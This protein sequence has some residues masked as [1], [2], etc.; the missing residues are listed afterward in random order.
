M[1]PDHSAAC[2]GMCLATRGASSAPMALFEYIFTTDGRRD[3]PVGA[4][5]GIEATSVEDA[6]QILFLTEL[7]ERAIPGTL[8]VRPWRSGER[9]A[10]QRFVPTR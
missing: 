7:E 2:G 1:R 10:V 5:R 8:K 9:W 6:I 4:P 3:E